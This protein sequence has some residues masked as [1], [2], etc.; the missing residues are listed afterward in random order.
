MSKCTRGALIALNP[1]GKIVGT[2]APAASF[3]PGDVSVSLRAVFVSDARNGLVYGLLPRRKGLR[4]INRVEAG[5]SARGTALS[6]DGTS[7]IVADYSRGVGAIDL[8]TGKTSWLRRR[9]GRTL[10][11]IDGLVRCGERYFGV[12]NSGPTGHIISIAI[13]AGAIDAHDVATGAQLSDPTEIA[14]DGKNLLVVAQSGWG[15]VGKAQPKRR[16]GARIIE[17]P[18]QGGCNS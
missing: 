13:Q 15:S 8:K 4:P 11:G 14:F 7:V 17:I 18:L 2:L 3:H 16:D 1:G 12:N 6:P 9:D 10:S 5:K